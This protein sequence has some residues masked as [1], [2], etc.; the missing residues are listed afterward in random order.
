MRLKTVDDV[1]SSLIVTAVACIREINGKKMYLKGRV[2]ITRSPAIHPGDVQY[3]W[4]IG[5]PPSDSPFSYEDFPNCVVFP[6]QGT[7]LMYFIN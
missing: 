5:S 3:A 4:A 6:C 7:S 2:L 1:C